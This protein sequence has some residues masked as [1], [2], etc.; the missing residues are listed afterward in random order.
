M[1][2][3][4]VALFHSLIVHYENDIP[5]QLED[6]LVNPDIAPLYLQQ[7]FT[8]TTP[9]A[10][11]TQLAPLTAGEHTIEAVM[12]GNDEQ[13]LTADNGG[14]GNDQGGFMDTDYGDDGGGFFSD[15]DSF[16]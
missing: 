12:A 9:F 13:R 10:Y 14:Y 11:L 5:V 2:P 15:D 8:K 7:D 1:L 16:V 6:R 4:G 3:P